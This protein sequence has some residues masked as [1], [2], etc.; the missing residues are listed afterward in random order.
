ML[1]SQDFDGGTIG[2]WSC[3]AFDSIPQEIIMSTFDHRR[4]HPAQKDGVT[5]EPLPGAE[6]AVL[7]WAA[8]RD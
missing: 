5:F 1:C 7:E 3:K 4:K 6:N 8:Q 2:T